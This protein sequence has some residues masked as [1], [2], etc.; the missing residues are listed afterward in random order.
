MVKS[1]LGSWKDAPAELARVAIPQKDI[2]PRERSSLLRDM[3]VSQQPD[4][5]RH[6]QR[7][8]SRMDGR[9]IRF[10]RLG[11]TLEHQDHGAADSRD[12]DRL[13]SR[14][15][16]QDRLLHDGWFSNG[17]WHGSGWAR[18]PSDFRREF[19]PGRPTELA[20]WIHSPKS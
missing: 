2:L 1:Q 19:R 11:H 13:K 18:L 9:L 14:V 8:R 20:R 16:D 6:F 10:F 17:R 15:Q 5:G 4:N 3:P 12:I 7:S